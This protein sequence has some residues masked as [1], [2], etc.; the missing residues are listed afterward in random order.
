MH[1]AV[2]TGIMPQHNNNQQVGVYALRNAQT[3]VCY[4]GKSTNIENRVLQH[5]NENRPDV[6]RRESVLTQGS[7]ND[8]ESWERNEVLTRMYREG[9]ESVRG[10][11]YTRRGPLTMDEK[12]S[13][14]NDIIEKFDLC[15]RCGLDS[16]FADKCFARST[17]Y[18]C[19]DI[20]VV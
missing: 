5:Q 16:H 12:I 8:L 18:W 14:R 9:M 17:A 2:N 15:R 7:T 10:W 3:N 1:P 11:R 6:L 20:I 13:A 19:E 4:V